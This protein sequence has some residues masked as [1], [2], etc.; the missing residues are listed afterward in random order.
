MPFKRVV[1][2]VLLMGI[3]IISIPQ[4]EEKQPEEP[5]AFD[6][7]LDSIGVTRQEL[8]GKVN[9]T[10]MFGG[11]SPVSFSG[12][13]R[14]KIG[15]QNIESDVEWMQDDRTYVQSGWEGNESLIRMGMV[16][17][18]GR[19][20]VL[21]SKIGFQ[22][23]MPGNRWKPP[24]SDVG[25]IAQM[26]HDKSLVMANIHED[27]NAGIAVRTVPASFWLKMGN[28]NWIEASPF[29]VWKA[30][31]RTFAWE[32]LPYEVEQPIARYYEYNIAKGEKAGRAA[33]HKKAFNGINFESI[34]L[35]HR[36]YFNFV[37]GA[38]ERYDNFEQEYTDFSNDLAYAGEGF[39]VK[40]TG[41]GDSYRHAFHTRI[42]ANKLIGELT[43]GLNFIR[44]DY[45]DDVITS[46]DNNGYL[47]LKATGTGNVNKGWN[48]G[49][50]DTL[51]GTAFYKEPKV[52]SLDV[53]GPMLNRLLDVHADIAFGNVDTTYLVWKQ[54]TAT[55]ISGNYTKEKK[56]SDLGMAFYSRLTFDTRIPFQLDIAAIG[57]G[58]YSPLSFAAP[59]DAFYAFNSNM[60]GS[61]KFIGRGEASP[62]VQNMAGALLTVMPKLPGYGHLRVAYGQHAQL[63]PGRDILYLQYRLN[64]LDF[65]SFWQSSYMRWGN[66]P[67]HAPNY[68][69][70]G[71]R[72]GNESFLTSGYDS[73]PGMESGGVFTDFLSSTYCFVPWGEDT[74]AMNKNMLSRAQ[75]VSYTRVVDGDTSTT[76]FVPVNRKFTNNFE[77]DVAYDISGM[78][79]YPNDF[80]LGGYFALNNVAKALTPLAL[81]D[82]GDETQ[83]WSM[84]LR[85]EPAIAVTK[86]FYVLG[87][88]GFENWRSQ[89]SYMDIA[90]SA[91]SN[92]YLPGQQP[93]LTS[94]EHRYFKVPIDFQD[95]ALGLGFDWEILTRV[96]LHGR[97]KYMWHKDVNFSYNDWE[98]P[99]MS[100]EIKTWF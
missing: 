86:R 3:G 97:F 9:S 67:I 49:L 51:E 15:Y 25:E 74:S 21:W 20:T 84:Y 64:G 12:E 82:K 69:Q 10:K 47:F 90:D 17:R 18:A 36:L 65:F 11:S 95:G 19:N 76:A 33:W 61:G 57:K 44:L 58:F 45:N 99:V 62:Y 8:Q 1:I 77:V 31:P 37:Y 54:D 89:K 39:P 22:H 14:V 2:T 23:T 52:F 50:P 70:L 30:Q 28:V 26:R 88:F 48:R 41:I 38:Y 85:F 27:M 4:A 46:K 78:I 56:T 66:G 35:P 71:R 29:T 68:M 92:K 96:G 6:E 98:T 43:P 42:A 32:F 5:S 73:P 60:V 100:M 16:V 34:N 13:G 59:Q 94:G 80:F 91:M 24:S 83:L 7:L 81:G 79:N 53:R 75:D 93:V 40:G 87:I 63:E 72:L 55:G